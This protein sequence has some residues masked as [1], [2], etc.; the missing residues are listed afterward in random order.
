MKLYE[1]DFAAEPITENERIAWEEEHAYEHSRIQNTAKIP[2]FVHPDKNIRE[3]LW[4]YRSLFPNNHLYFNKYA[5]L[6]L[7]KEA[8]EFR[9][10]IYEKK[11]EQ[12]IQR[13][14][15]ENK[16]WFIPGSIFLDYNFGHHDAYLFP[17]QPLGE[18]YKAD[19]MLLGKNS[20]GYSIILVEFEKADVPFMITT[21]NTES[22][23]VREGLTQ[24][25]DWKRWLDDNRTYFL[26]SIGLTSLGIEVPTYRIYYYLVVS[27]REHMGT[28][29]TNYRSQ[30]MYE[31][32]N[33]KIVTYDRLAD[34][35]YNLS[36]R[37]NW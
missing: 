19:Y 4:H 17:E 31:M 1:R 12:L 27:N 20:D 2:R 9:N 23:R 3:F 36:T 29:E 15:K 26:N 8:E 32:P 37:P 34:N 35:V 18:K 14:I 28:R 5:Y 25:R 22:Q 6:D 33:L 24:I 10:V 21:S 16:K 7:K 13:Y 11:E 30:L